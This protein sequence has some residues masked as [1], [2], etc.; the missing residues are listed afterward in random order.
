MRHFLTLQK[1]HR[2]CDHLFISYSIYCAI[3]SQDFLD[4]CT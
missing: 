4:L 2:P 1:V 3:V